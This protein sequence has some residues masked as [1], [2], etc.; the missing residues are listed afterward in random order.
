M[1]VPALS[2]T[3]RAGLFGAVDGMSAFIGILAGLVVAHQPASAVWWAALS[4]GL[5]E[6]VG[7]TS[8]QYQSDAASGWGAA[9]TCGTLSMAGCVVPALPYLV[10][11]GPLALVLAVLLVLIECGLIA[12]LRPE[13]GW[14][15]C[16]Q[17]FGLTAAVAVVCAAAATL[18]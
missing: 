9:L 10:L 18:A 17:T 7:M 15:A 3:T 14:R 13:R 11:S 8:G 6:L 4:C 5:A 1:T 12:W 16:L 2:P